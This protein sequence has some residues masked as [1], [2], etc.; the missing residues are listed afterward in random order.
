ML[1][2]GND[3]FLRDSET[4]SLLS[5]SSTLM[6]GIVSI[7]TVFLVPGFVYGKVT[8]EYKKW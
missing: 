5:N 1:S 4:G 7:I 2:I 3:A 8:K 6:K